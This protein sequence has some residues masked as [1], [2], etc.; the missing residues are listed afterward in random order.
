MWRKIA[1]GI[2]DSQLFFTVQRL[3]VMLGMT[4]G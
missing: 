3:K 4:G 1:S 2:F